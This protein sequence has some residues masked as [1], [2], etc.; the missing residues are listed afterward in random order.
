MAQPRAAKKLQGHTPLIH[1]A[2]ELPSV[3]VD[4]YNNETRE[5]GQFVGDKANKG[6]FQEKLHHWRKVLRDYGDDPLGK[7][8]TNTVSKKKVDALLESKNVSDVALA[9]ATIEDFS[10]DFADVITKFMAFKAWAKT[11]RI[12]VGGGFRESRTGE[13]AIA[14]TMMILRAGG[15]NVD[16]VPVAQHPDD[17]GLIGSVH[18]MPAWMLKGHNA[19][20]AV[21]IGGTNIRAG[22]VEFAREKHRIVDASVRDSDIWRHTDDE[23]SRSAAVERLADML[24]TLVSNQGKLKLA[25][26]I[27][28]GCPGIVNP[29]GA[30][31]RGAHNLPG[32][33]WESDHFNLPTAITKAIPCIGGHETFVMMHNDAV[34][35]GLS[36]LPSMGDVS[37]WGVMTI[38]T[39]LGNARFTNREPA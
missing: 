20:L 2:L 34:V 27:G 19:I 10:R 38:G 13:I 8:L 4:D 35:Q 22:I 9:M 29:D 37:R 39:G 17:A 14:R 6:A 28:I 7:T 23:P 26:L 1:G 30:I 5:R 25:P 36:Q 24:N 18:L 16:L 11:E 32:G 3:L 15:L 31:E 21:D 33:N 12:V